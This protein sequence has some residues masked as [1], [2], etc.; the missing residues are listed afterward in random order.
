MY[1]YKLIVVLNYFFILCIL[2]TIG[3][4]GLFRVS[5]YTDSEPPPSQ[6]NV[7]LFTHIIAGFSSVKNG[8]IDVGDDAHKKLYRDVTALK[9]TNPGLKILLT[10]GGGG[11]FNGFTQACGSLLN[12]TRFVNFFFLLF[13]DL[14]V[15]T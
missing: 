9:Q 7:T 6:L 10:I 3:E 14:F 13:I 12:R 11:N 15:K 2:C 1:D 5:Y 8:L 4:S